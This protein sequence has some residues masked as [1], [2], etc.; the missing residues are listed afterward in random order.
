MSEFSGMMVV[1]CIIIPVLIFIVG[2]A[3]IKSSRFVAKMFMF[4]AISWTLVTSFAIPPIVEHH[5][6]T[7]VT[8]S[9]APIAVAVSVIFWLMLAVSIAVLIGRTALNRKKTTNGIGGKIESKSKSGGDEYHD[10][11][12]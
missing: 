10:D 12:L 5:G 3:S 4:G 1:S 2:L 6:C 7:E 9:D 11:L 8:Y